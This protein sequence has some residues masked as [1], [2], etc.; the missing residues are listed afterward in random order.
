MSCSHDDECD[1]YFAR[2]AS[3]MATENQDGVA[4]SCLSPMMNKMIHKVLELMLSSDAEC[5]FKKARHL[6]HSEKQ[7]S[8]FGST[9]SEEGL[10]QVG[11][12]VP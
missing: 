2:I 1:E 6:P 10:R 7:H 11:L 4:T 12:I 9:G 5:D 8:L 3:V